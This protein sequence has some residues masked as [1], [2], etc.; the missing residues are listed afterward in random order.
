MNLLELEHAL[1]A[2]GYCG[3]YLAGG[4][5]D[6]T[7][8]LNRTADG[9]ETYYCERGKRYQVC[10]FGTEDEACRYFI[11]WMTSN[12]SSLRRDNH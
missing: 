4:L 10:T 5:L 1:I 2:G 8:T 9:W 3:W 12:G 6:D 11:A 7:C